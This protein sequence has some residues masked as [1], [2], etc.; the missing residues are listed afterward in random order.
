[1]KY[2]KMLGLLAVAA[3]AFMAFAA[4]ASAT[5][6]TS[7]EGTTYTG[8]IVAEAEG[9]GITV[10]GPADINCG[11]SHVEGEVEGHGSSVTATGKISKW[12]FEQCG[13]HLTI[14]TKGSLAVHTDAETSNG[15][16]TLTASGSS[17]RA[18][19]TSLG[20]SCT[21]STNET[22]IGTLTGSNVTG[23]TATLDINSSP[24]P[25]TGGSFFCGSSG[26]LTG[27]YVITSPSTF[28]VD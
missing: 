3:A 2:V 22:D 28:Y 8:K 26:A 13:V 16:G 21:Y 9:G 10:D 24:I 7:P 23:G 19:I 12:T 11:E 25:R 14:E 20:I 15:N 6:V 18:D 5:T 1:M 17:L 4:T 27:S